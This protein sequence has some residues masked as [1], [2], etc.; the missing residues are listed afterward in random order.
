MQAALIQ[1]LWGLVFVFVDIKIDGIDLLLPDIIGYI[2]IYFALTRLANMS[3]E[4]GKARP[5]VIAAAV[6]WLLEAFHVNPFELVA[7]ALTIAETLIIWYVC[8]GIVLLALERNDV[9]L[10]NTAETRRKLYF[11][12]AVASLSLLAL[13]HAVPYLAAL[14]VIPMVALSLTAGALILLLLRRASLELR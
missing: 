4:F 10:A 3:A 14:L 8:T 11:V 2:L 5:H 1:I 7:I 12:A 13:A 9:A 6:L